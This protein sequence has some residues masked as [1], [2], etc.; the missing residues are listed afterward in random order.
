MRGW[1][2]AALCVAVMGCSEGGDGNG[3]TQTQTTGSGG[4]AGSGGQ[5]TSSTTGSAGG[6][7][8]GAAGH[9]L[10]NEICAK[11]EDWIE[12]ANPT[13]AALDIGE[14]GLCGDVDPTAGHECDSESI[15]RF[16]KGTT[17]PPG[18]YLLI[19]GDQDSALGV[20]PHVECLA[21]GGPTT[22]FYAT[23]KVSA[24][25]G[26]MVH[27]LD[28]GDAVVDEALYPKDAAGDGQSWARLPDLSGGFAVAEPTPGA[29]NKAP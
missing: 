12:L 2:L 4:G 26:E 16:P 28:D 14:F 6:G 18:G 13:A 8:G 3:T 22:C 24:S 21:S 10:I 9:A 1:M 23:W 19:V 15:V 17:L 25:N 20:G 11:G 7:T 29:A 5:G 27:L